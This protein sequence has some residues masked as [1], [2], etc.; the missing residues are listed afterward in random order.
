[1]T[2]KEPPRGRVRPVSFSTSDLNAPSEVFAEGCSPGQGKK[3]S[4][5]SLCA[6][7][8]RDMCKLW[9]PRD[10]A[11]CRAVALEMRTLT[12]QTKWLHRALRQTRAWPVGS[13]LS[14]LSLGAGSSSAGDGTV[15]TKS[16]SHHHQRVFQE[17]HHQLTWVGS[18]PK[19]DHPNGSIHHCHTDDPPCRPAGAWGKV[20]VLRLE[21]ILG[22]QVPSH[23]HLMICKQEFNV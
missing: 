15:W 7:W 20:S 23:A 4:T 14:W 12:M 22:N 1:M 13:R 2:I 19:C 18:N 11:P 5:S 9:P 21:P 6:I 3:A 8:L 16:C 17:N 10:A